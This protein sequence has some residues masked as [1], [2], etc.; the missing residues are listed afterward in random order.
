MVDFQSRDTTRGLS[1]GDDDGEDED[2]DE[3]EAESG[4]AAAEA[5]EETEV[6]QA[7]TEAEAGVTETQEG[8]G[9]PG[10]PDAATAETAEADSTDTGEADTAGSTVGE[11]ES[12]EPARETAAAGAAETDSD[13]DESSHDHA[14][15]EDGHDHA[16]PA[17]G[18]DHSHGHGDSHDHSHADHHHA[19]VEQLG[20][21]VV[22]VSSSRSLDDDPSG[23]AA[24][25]LLEEDGH[26][27]VAR[28]LVADDLDGVQRAVLALTGREDIDVVVTTGGTGVTPDDVTV[29][30]VEP[31]FDKDLPGFGELFR[32]LSYEEVG[33]RAMGSRATAGVSEGVPV[34]CLPGSEDAVRTGVD[35]LILAEAPHL[36]G[37]ANDE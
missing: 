3:V 22:T 9:E 26:S 10:E 33:T 13:P 23:D 1:S 18:H 8:D 25:E 31:L 20:V 14:E 35:E 16:E 7:D 17:D 19:D 21:A 6:E 5:P 36:V 30:A 12:D 34:F 24:Q 32:I 15:T 4:D 11:A 27:V 29:E 2:E 28:D 37:L